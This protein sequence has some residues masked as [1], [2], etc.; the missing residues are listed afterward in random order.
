[1]EK[2]E[3]AYILSPKAFEISCSKCNGDNITWS[4][5]KHHIW[6]YD[7]Q[8]DDPG[9]GG[10]FDSPIPINL[11]IML[12]NHFDRV[13]LETGKIELFNFFDNTYTPYDELLKSNKDFA[14]DLLNDDEEYVI[15]LKKKYGTN[16]MQRLFRYEEIMNDDEI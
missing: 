10:I 11:S 1:M 7:C 5:Y 12:G 8:I 16:V 4:E 15:E 3:W 9:T 13:D 14:K 2:R 6:C